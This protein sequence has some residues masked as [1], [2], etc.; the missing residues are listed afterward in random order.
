[1][2][3]YKKKYTKKEI[4]EKIGDISQ[5]GGIKQYEFND[6]VSRGIRAIDLRNGN[7]LALTVLLD[8]GFDI[9]D[10]TYR[11][12]SIVWKSI[13]KETHPLYFDKDGNEW[14]K[15]F[16]GG[17]LT[18]CGLTYFGPPCEDRGEKL[19]LHGRI[20]N[21]QAYNISMDSKWEGDDY[22]IWVK[23]RV[24]EASVFGD[25]L[26]MERKISMKF[27]DDKIYIEDRI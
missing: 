9:S 16:Y 22:W 13:T 23:G 19:G 5:I 26:E 4:L 21:I 20:S 27:G 10:V 2:I 18:T 25:K 24:R 8:R 11:G 1:M 3:I 15:T 14:L 12:A 7:G 17:L 6:G